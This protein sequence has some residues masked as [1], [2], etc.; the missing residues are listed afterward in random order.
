MHVRHS[1]DW[2][3]ENPACSELRAITS[4]DFFINKI[5]KSVFLLYNQNV[6]TGVEECPSF[7]QDYHNIPTFTHT[8]CPP[9][10]A[11]RLAALKEGVKLVIVD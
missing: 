2:I 6:L 5:A 7:Q 1:Y 10:A 8:R 11:V 9:K 4:T 3:C